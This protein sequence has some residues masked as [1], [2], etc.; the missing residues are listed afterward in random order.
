MPLIL[1]NMLLIITN[2]ADIHPNPVIQK[3]NDRKIPVF[4][5]NTDRLLTDYDISFFLS[6]DGYKFRIKYKVYPFELTSEEI[7]CVWERRPMEPEATYDDINNEIIKNTVLNEANGFIR[8][9]RYALVGMDV[10]WIGHPINERLA[11]SKILQKMIAQRIG[12]TIPET[13]FSNKISDVNFFGNQLI[14]LKPICSF[15]IPADEENSIVFY[16]QKVTGQQLLELG[17]KSFRNTINFLEQYIEKDYELRVTMIH[18]KVFCA[19]VCSQQQKETEGAIDWRQGYD[20]GLRFEAINIPEEL[21]S[22]CIQFLN[23][24]NLQF[25]CFDFIKHGSTYI[26]LE[27][28]T[29]GQWL[30]LEEETGLPISDCLA[31]LFTRCH[32]EHKKMQ[33]TTI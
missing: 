25:G 26:F 1:Y 8:F 28:N 12:F 16:T 17:E 23:Y 31:Q 7:S 22:K 3:L 33:K 14:A 20:H 2:S 6:N 10:L 18:G 30:W 29:N 19:K 21:K 15:D 32:E 11:G 13:I 5:F 9:L 4:R 24:F 27:C